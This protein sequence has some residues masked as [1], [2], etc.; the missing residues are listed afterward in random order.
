MIN[1]ATEEVVATVAARPRVEETDAAIARAQRGLRG[2]AARRAGRAGAAAARFAAAGR[3]ARR[4]A[5][6]ARGAQLR[7][8]HRQRRWEAGN[9][10][11]VLHFY[12]ARRN[13]CPASRFRCRAASTSPS[14]SR[15]AWSASSCRGTSRCPSRLGVRAGPGRGQHGRAQTGRADPADRDPARRAGHR[16]G[17]PRGVFQ[18]LPGRARW[19]AN[20]SSPTRTCARSCFT[21]STEVGKR[22]M[23]RLRRPGEAADA[24]ARRQERQHRLRRRRP[25]RA[26]APHHTSVFDNAGQDCCARSRILVQRNLY[27]RFLELLE[28]AVAAFRVQDPGAGDGRDGPADLGRF[29]AP[30]LESL[31]DGADVAFR[32]SCP[33]GAAPPAFGGSCFFFF[34]FFFFFRAPGERGDLRAGGVGPAPSTTRTRHCNWPPALVQ[35][36][37][38][39]HTQSALVGSRNALPP[40]SELR[41]ARV[42]ADT[43]QDRGTPA[44]PG[45]RDGTLTTRVSVAQVA[46]HRGTPP[47][48]RCA[49]APHRPPSAL[50]PRF[51]LPQFAPPGEPKDGRSPRRSWRCPGVAVDAD[52]RA[53]RL[54]ATRRLSCRSGF[55]IRPPPRLNPAMRQPRSPAPADSHRLA[56]AGVTVGGA[57]GEIDGSGDRGAHA[58]QWRFQRPLHTRRY[59]ARSPSCVSGRRHPRR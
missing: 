55:S 30:P 38:G 50:D 5:G 19:S 3:R 45:C 56:Q 7:A 1:P 40:R 9:V 31:M 10:R 13:A 2:V 8:H 46:S 36:A 53:A 6:R 52:C 57:A 37:G 17:P 33:T 24:G 58:L 25:R 14:T 21:G 15:S 34:F 23:A 39:D 4:G 48:S 43:W 27:D 42:D 44:P 18:V 47:R 26:A 29:S 54:S 41:P 28:P 35:F 49:R 11:D 32:G 12:S 16:G 22:I 51:D 20:G 59:R